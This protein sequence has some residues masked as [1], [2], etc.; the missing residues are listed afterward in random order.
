M[1]GALPNVQEGEIVLIAREN[2]SAVEKLFLRWRGLK[3]VFKSLE[4]FVFQV[5][6]LRNGALKIYTVPVLNYTGIR[7]W[8]KNK[9]RRT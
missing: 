3:R 9:F 1:K 8:I 6:D 4:Y 2:F 7:T 5:K